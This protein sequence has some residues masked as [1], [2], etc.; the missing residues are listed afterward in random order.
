MGVAA[1]EEFFAHAGAVS[2]EEKWRQ[3]ELLACAHGGCMVRSEEEERGTGRAALE[4]KERERKRGKLCRWGKRE[5]GRERM[6]RE[7]GFQPK[8]KKQ[9]LFDFR[10]LENETNQLGF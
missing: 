5:M 7:I 10:I 4:E 3:W 1:G 6:D 9:F 8:R 2:E